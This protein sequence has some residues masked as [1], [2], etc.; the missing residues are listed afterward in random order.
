MSSSSLLRFDGS[1]RP[2]LS[3]SYFSN[4]GQTVKSDFTRWLEEH[5]ERRRQRNAIAALR[6]MSD[7]GLKDIG[8][9]RGEVASVIRTQ[10]AERRRS[11]ASK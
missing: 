5:N 7:Y 6:G 8:L 1:N 3:W 9:S 4:W 11:F 10:G 2:G